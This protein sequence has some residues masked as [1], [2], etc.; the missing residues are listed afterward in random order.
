MTKLADLSLRAFADEVAADV[1]APGGGSAAALAGSVGAALVCMVCRLSLERE[2]VEATDEELAD[3]LERGETLRR[4]LLDL[5][6]EDTAAFEAFM[7]AIRMPKETDV[8][9][10]ARSLALADAKLG[11][12]VPPLETLAA[13]RK[14]LALAES[15][16]GRSNANVVSDL[17]VAAQLALAAAEGALLNV[18]INLST[19]PPGERVDTLR[20]DS[21]AEITAARATAAAVTSE[22]A[23]SLGL[24]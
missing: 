17:G 24:E 11:A 21:E 16:V 5:V 12:T 14:V 22:V 6:D 20:V 8:E 10:E 19:L 9:R 18:A 13:S 3:A 2:D 15:L 23:I 7:T 4:R 1:P